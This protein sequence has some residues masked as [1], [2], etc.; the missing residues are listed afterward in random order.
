MKGDE[1]ESCK[2]FHIKRSCDNEELAKEINRIDWK[3]T[4]LFYSAV[5]LVLARMA[6][7][8]PSKYGETGEQRA[9]RSHSDLFDFIRKDKH[10]QQ[11]YKPYNALFELSRRARY[12]VWEPDDYDLEKAIRAFE[13]V[14]KLF[15][16]TFPDLQKLSRK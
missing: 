14:K 7:Y 3:I 10:L 5:H 9:H 6:D 11:I 16:S 2:K 4:I 12:E 1:I 8:M 13:R 15:F